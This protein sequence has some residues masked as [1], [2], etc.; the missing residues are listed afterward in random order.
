MAELQLP[1]YLVV[2]KIVTNDLEA[3]FKE[4]SRRL[5]TNETRWTPLLTGS[6]RSAT[7]TGRW[8]RG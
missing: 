1:K 8:G 7:C 3:V 6:F 5:Q 4:V 2:Y